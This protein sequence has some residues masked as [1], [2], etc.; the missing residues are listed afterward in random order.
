MSTL[1][2]TRL[3]EL[4]NYDPD[5]GEF[6]W[7]QTVANRLCG[8]RAGANNHGYRQIRIERKLYQAHRLAWCY[9]YG[10][11]PPYM[12][13]HIN[14]IKGDN[15]IANL[16]LA[17]NQENQQNRRTPQG[18]NPYIGVSWNKAAKRWEAQIRLQGK[19]TY[20]GRFS[21]PEEAH[22]AYLKAKR[23]GHTHG[24]L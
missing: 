13:D 16:R 7:R 20:L 9:V 14:G 21:T 10:V 23:E 1:D 8:T 5:T 15:R 17:T 6:T 3:R 2:S 4:L 18:S 19:P 24:T 22:A 11:W 12:V